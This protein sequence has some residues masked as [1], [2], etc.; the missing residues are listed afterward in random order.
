MVSEYE[1]LA[2]HPACLAVVLLSNM[3]AAEDPVALVAEHL[4]PHDEIKDDEGAKDKRDD[5][6]V[7]RV[8]T[9]DSLGGLLDD[10]DMML[11]SDE[12]DEDATDANSTAAASETEASSSTTTVKAENKPEVIDKK[13]IEE[14]L[15]CIVCQTDVRMRK[16]VCGNCC[17]AAVRRLR[18]D[19][20]KGGPAQRK[21]FE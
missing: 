10:I 11:D 6:N 4:K 14:L 12:E 13:M 1:V 20:V 21:T 17:A 7:S 8:S 16:Q 9:C 18:R 19:A 2:Q 15:M 5:D 3:V